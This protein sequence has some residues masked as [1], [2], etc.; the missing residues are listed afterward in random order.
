M[1]LFDKSNEFT[2]ESGNSFSSGSDSGSDF[3]NWRLIVDGPLNG[4]LNMAIDKSLLMASEMSLVTVPTLRIYSWSEP[5]VS[6]GYGQ[7][8]EDFVFKNIETVKRVTGGRALVHGSDLSYA[9]VCP[10]ES[11]KK[12]G[13]NL[14]DTYGAISLAL[15]RGLKGIGIEV[16]SGNEIF[17]KEENPELSRIKRA[18][19]AEISPYELTVKSVRGYKKISGNAQRRLKNSFIQHG[20]IMIDSNGLINEEVFGKNFNN[21]ATDASSETGKSPEE[22][23]GLLAQGIIDGF[24]M[25]FG[26]EFD[27]SG[28]AEI[29][30]ELRYN[31]DCK[32]G[33]GNLAL[34]RFEAEEACL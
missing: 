30:K 19:F 5:T 13:A 28:Y 12:F 22:L 29:E 26:I 33:S 7:K 34:N 3:K 18:C 8:S 31:I 23:R 17:A 15:A 24:K 9:F 10:K 21:S 11:F 6:I 25:Q 27:S 14:M 16:S 2:D 32:P 4:R 1:P 20:S